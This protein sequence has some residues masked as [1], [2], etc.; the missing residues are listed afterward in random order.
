[1]K[2]PTKNLKSNL[3]YKKLTA[4]EE[5]TKMKDLIITNVDKDR[6]V[7]IMDTDSQIKEANQQLSNKAS[8]KQLT[9]D[10]TLQHER[11][12]NQT[13]ETF[14]NEKL[15]PQKTT[16]GLKVSN[17]KTPKFMFHQEAITQ[18]ILEYQ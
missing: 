15:L 17:L 12:V 11:I 4:M 2:Q 10:P 1:M 13:I 9:Q 16:D 14:K 5:L 3:T 6:A 8:Y 18:I 7:V